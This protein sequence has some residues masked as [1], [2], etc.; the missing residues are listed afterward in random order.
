[1]LVIVQID[2]EGVVVKS[3]TCPAIEQ[4]QLYDLFSHH[5][6]GL[7]GNTTAAEVE[8]SVRYSKTQV[9]TTSTAGDTVSA[10]ALR[11]SLLQH[12]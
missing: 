7:Q 9:I 4:L 6:L 12:C 8:C 10:F 11:N 5:S 2:L 1:M 3:W